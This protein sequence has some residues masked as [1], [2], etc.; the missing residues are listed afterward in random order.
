MDV[1]K[2]PLSARNLTPG[3]KSCVLHAQDSWE[4]AIA[5]GRHD[6]FNKLEHKLQ[7]E[8]IKTYLVADGSRT[9]KGLL[10]DR[11]LH[12][13][14][15]DEP[16]FAPSVLHAMPSYIWGFWYFDE[17]GVRWN[18]SLR[19][20]QFCAHDVD[21]Q[22]AEYFFNGV[23]G[24]MLRENVSKISQGARNDA[25]LTPATAVIFLQDIEGY[26]QR[27]WYLTTEEMI[28]TTAQAAGAGMVYVK[29]HPQ[30]TKASRKRLTELCARHPNLRLSD[31]SLHDLIEAS[32][33]V[34][35]QNSA[36]GF[37]ALMQRKTV[38]TCAK[39][40]FWHATLTPRSTEDLKAA[41]EFGPE[42]MADFPF[43]KYFYWF[44]DRMCLE[45][46]KD[47][48]EDRLWARIREKL[49]VI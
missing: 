36:A 40:D 12:I 22:A 27:S 39:T 13:M 16:L 47:N 21:A 15:R 31:A 25:P 4:E 9:A 44:L 2:S 1:L 49:M 46:S 14:V 19:F 18:S 8:G 41:I 33:M 42:A 30:Q 26:Q 28:T 17:V 10:P 23:S 37:E 29:F 5:Q 6:F 43:E 35:T 48:F 24:W 32:Q 20:A 3:Y 11:H 34:V 7:S 38:I 45:P